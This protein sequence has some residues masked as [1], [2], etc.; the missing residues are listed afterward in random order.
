VGMVH[1]DILL[2][3]HVENCSGYHCPGYL[4]SSDHPIKRDHPTFVASL[5]H[6]S[7]P[8]RIHLK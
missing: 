7:H 6:P 8:G 1:A 2:Q 4:G 3:A 5:L